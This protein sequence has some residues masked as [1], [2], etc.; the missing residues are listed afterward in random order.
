MD[1]MEI[2]NEIEDVIE[3][4]KTAI[5]SNKVAVNKEEILELISDLRIKLPDE[6]KQAKWI[7]SE[8]ERILNEA[9]ME[10]EKVIND[11][12]VELSKLLSEESVLIEAQK[13]ANDMILNAKEQS[14]KIIVGS[15]DYTDKFIHET[16]TNLKNIIET[17]NE[18]RRQ[19]QDMASSV[20]KAK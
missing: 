11:A 5:L 4:A 2:I 14:A 10:G 13:R 16:Q 6:I 15:V 7:K 8:R 1:V 3:G 17:L 20:K 19:L 18:N 12:K 9:R